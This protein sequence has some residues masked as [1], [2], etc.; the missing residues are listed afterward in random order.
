MPNQ[1]QRTCVACRTIRAPAE[2]LR[3]AAR[4]GDAPQLD[5]AGKLKASGRGAYL[6]RDLECARKAWKRRAFERALKLKTPLDA[7][8]VTQVE[9]A[10]QTAAATQITSQES[11]NMN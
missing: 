10:I 4:D 11:Q 5:D 8:F 7:A 1:P 9:T 6:C 3:I 2:M